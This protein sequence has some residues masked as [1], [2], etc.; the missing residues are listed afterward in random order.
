MILL[1]YVLCPTLNPFCRCKTTAV[2]TGGK[3]FG[4][5]KRTAH[6][7]NGQRIQRAQIWHQMRQSLLTAKGAQAA[8]A[9]ED[10]VFFRVPA[11]DDLCRLKDGQPDHPGHKTDVERIAAKPADAGYAL[12]HLP[13]NRP[14]FLF[15]RG[16][17][18]A[19][20]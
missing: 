13:V 6:P 11:Q 10:G 19:L 8:L 20:F 16:S 12:P 15:Q 18:P 3:G 9:V 2:P 5:V 14:G 7:V 4:P 1:L 17:I